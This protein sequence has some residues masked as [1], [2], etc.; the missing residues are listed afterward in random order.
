MLWSNEIENSM[1]ATAF[2]GVMDP[3]QSVNEP[4]PDH[5]FFFTNKI[6]IRNSAH[7]FPPP[8]PSNMIA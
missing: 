2:K 6:G 7:P 4:D 3:D 1:M 8:F 5:R